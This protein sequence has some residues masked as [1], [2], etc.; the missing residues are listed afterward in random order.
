M[1]FYENVILHN[2]LHFVAVSH[3]HDF[4]TVNHTGHLDLGWLPSAAE[5][6]LIFPKSF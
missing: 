6:Y 2:N 3:V 4:A 5:S 1:A